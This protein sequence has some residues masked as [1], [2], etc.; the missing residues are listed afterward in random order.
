[1][2]STNNNIE[3]WNLSDVEKA[4]IVCGGSYTSASK[5]QN[6]YMT[7]LMPLISIGK[8]KSTPTSLNKSCI[9]NDTSCKPYVS[10][11]VKSLNYFTVSLP[12][13]Q[14]FGHARLSYGA[15]VEV[16]VRD[17]NPDYMMLHN[18]VDPSWDPVY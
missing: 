8:P 18:T 9:I 13:N 12:D 6:V 4:K 14:S 3:V 15:T 7:K 16:Y 5:T 1:M 11:T 2:N 17:K 10:S